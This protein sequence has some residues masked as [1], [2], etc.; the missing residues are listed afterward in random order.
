MQIATNNVYNNHWITTGIK[1][2]LKHKRFFI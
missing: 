2:S 1:I